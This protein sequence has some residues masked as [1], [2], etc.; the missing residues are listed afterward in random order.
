MKCA[1]AST[2][3]LRN[4]FVFGGRLVQTPDIFTNKILAT[5]EQLGAGES[6]YAFFSLNP[7]GL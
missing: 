6:N 3:M 4:S 7:Q 5:A 1:F 2:N